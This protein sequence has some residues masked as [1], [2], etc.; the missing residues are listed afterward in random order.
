MP[1]ALDRLLTSPS[2]LRLLR[3]AINTPESP[4]AY[5]GTTATKCCTCRTHPRR[6]YQKPR[7]STTPPL[8]WNRLNQGPAAPETRDVQLQDG[9]KPYDAR[10]WAECLQ[11]K[12]RI[13]GWIGI[14]QIWAARDGVYDLPTSDTPDAE[15]LWATFFTV[16]DLVLPVILHAV[17]VRRKTGHLHPRLYELCMGYWLPRER[18]I[19]QVPHYH[20]YFLV[21][22]K[23]R[24]LP[25]RS[26][27]HHGKQRFTSKS[28]AAFMEI[29]RTSNEKDVYD[30]IV[31]TLYVRGSVRLAQQ[32]HTLCI[33]RGDRPSPEVAAVPAIQKLQA[34]IS[35]PTDPKAR[36]V[37]IYADRMKHGPSKLN[38]DL[39]RRLQ[40]RD[41]APVRFDDKLCAKLFATRSFS[42]ESVIQ[43]LA[44]VGVNEIGPLAVRAMATTAESNNVIKDS[45]EALKAAGIALQGT[46][47]SLALEK[48]ALD[49]R[50]GLVRSM[51]SSD[52]HS[53]VYDDIGQQKELL[54]YYLENQDFEQA[55]RTLAI[56][57]FFHNDMATESWN[58][59]L[60]AQVAQVAHFQPHQIWHTLENMRQKRILVYTQ[61][62]VS[63]KSLLRPRRRTRKP[64]NS[65]LLGKFDELRFVARIFLFVME[66]ELGTVSPLIWREI[67]RRYGML[68]RLRE[69]RRL[70]YKLFSLYAPQRS[71]HDNL[72]RPP[73]QDSAISH[74]LG[75]SHSRPEATHWKSSKSMDQSYLEHP[76]RLLVPGALQQG[77][78]VWGFR[79]GILPNA[80]HERSMLGGAAPTKRFHWSVGLKIVVAL[81]DLGLEVHDYN[82]IKA[83]QALFIILFGAGRSVKRENN[84]MSLANT[85]SYAQMVEE[86]NEI[87]GAPLF[88]HPRNY[89]KAE[90]LAQ[91]WHPKLPRYIRR[92]ND[93]HLDGLGGEKALL[94][95]DVVG[96]KEAEELL[97]HIE[98]PEADFPDDDAAAGDDVMPRTMSASGESRARDKE[99]GKDALS[100]EKMHQRDGTRSTRVQQHVQHVQRNYDV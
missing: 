68:G 44:M 79:Q 73:F 83:L 21:H 47:F 16:P 64:Q 76:L 23:L 100:R 70:L 55:H 95:A 77:L 20:H 75:K 54:A 72:P 52:Q 86:V 14:R 24:K 4:T 10:T 63:I 45:F 81:R 94:D 35:D 50:W 26:L 1:S 60:Q 36:L 98:E 32:W 27:A 96:L 69:L 2:A 12:T 53:D 7:P 92:R 74:L 41:T 43:G 51:L 57:S 82:V 61:T 39:L 29:Y 59:L 49:E 88:V 48:F 87:W 40:G 46:V 5:L 19:D 28:Y 78:V 62:L 33:L 85:I 56:M 9:Q 17:E 8:N 34:S 22:L 11:Q 6:A 91:M 31:P 65:S 58:L 67:I 97:A 37:S 90:V 84:R 38:N 15:Y 89:G 80:P 42:V 66:N 13:G 93:H 30:E 71:E 99:L 18:Q 3:A 25:L